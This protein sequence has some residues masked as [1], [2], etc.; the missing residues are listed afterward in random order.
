V[1]NAA[2]EVAVA[3]FLARQLSFT[4]IHQLIQKTLERVPVRPADDLEAI[5]A[6]DAEARRVAGAQIAGMGEGERNRKMG[7]IVPIP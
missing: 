4:G 1:L 3:A 7:S 2:N 6:A 5:L